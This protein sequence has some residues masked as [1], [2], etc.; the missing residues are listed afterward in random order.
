MFE[1]WHISAGGGRLHARLL[2]IISL[3]KMTRKMRT[4]VYKAKVTIKLNEH[5]ILGRRS[6]AIYC[7]SPSGTCTLVI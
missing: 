1:Y 4:K 3:R 5:R 7:I 2:Q 6:L